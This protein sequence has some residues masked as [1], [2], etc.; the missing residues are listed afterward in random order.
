LFMILS[1]KC[2]IPSGFGWMLDH[3]S[4]RTD[5]EASSARNLYELFMPPL[6]SYSYSEIEALP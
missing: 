4:L 2:S 5:H 3:T 6:G 1:S